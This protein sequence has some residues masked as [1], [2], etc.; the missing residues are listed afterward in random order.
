M[1][2]LGCVVSEEPL[3][4]LAL[5]PPFSYCSSWLSPQPWGARWLYEGTGGSHPIPVP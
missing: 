2:F 3:A 5:C 1:W 4:L